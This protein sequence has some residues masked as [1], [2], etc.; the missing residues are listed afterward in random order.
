MLDWQ[1][2]RYFQISTLI[3]LL[4]C[5]YSPFTRAYVYGYT[6]LYRPDT[7]TTV[8]LLYDVHIKEAIRF[9]ELADE[10]YAGIKKRLFPS[11][12]R[13]LEAFERLNRSSSS[14]A[15]VW[16]SSRTLPWRSPYFVNYSDFLVAQR[17]LHLSFSHADSC[18]RHFEKA[19]REGRTVAGCSFANPFPITQAMK[20]ALTAYNG[21]QVWRAYTALRAQTLSNIQ[22]YGAHAFR[23]HRQAHPIAFAAW[24]ALTDLEMLTHILTSPKKHIIAYCGGAHLM[25]VAAFLKEHGRYHAIFEHNTGPMRRVGVEPEIDT[26]L[27]KLLDSERLPRRSFLAGLLSGVGRVMQPIANF[28]SHVS[29]L[30]PVGRRSRRHTPYFGMNL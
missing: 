5:M 18:R 21:H 1:E 6:R 14:V 17:F 23:N 4:G 8:D 15:I 28:A 26:A 10:S 27:L 25:T 30:V 24:S 13:V 19:C 3:L 9:K 16:E 20:S 2:M 7:Q 29:S 11:E 12:K 22:Q